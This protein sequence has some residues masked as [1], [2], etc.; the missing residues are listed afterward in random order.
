MLSPTPEEEITVIEFLGRCDLVEREYDQKAERR[1]W[2]MNPFLLELPWISRDTAFEFLNEN[3]RALAWMGVSMRRWEQRL[4]KF[5][6]SARLRD[7]FLLEDKMR[8]LRAYLQ[9]HPVEDAPVTGLLAPVFHRLW[10]DVGDPRA[11][12]YLWERRAA[13]FLCCWQPPPLVD[14]T[15][16]EWRSDLSTATIAAVRGV[17]KKR[18][19]A[20]AIPVPQG[21][22]RCVLGALMPNDQLLY[23]MVVQAYRE[24][25]VT[26]VRVVTDLY[27]AECHLFTQVEQ[28][29]T[30][31]AE[32][33][34]T[35][36]YRWFKT[37]RDD[38]HE[39]ME[40]YLDRLELK[41]AE[42]NYPLA[43][44]GLQS[45]QR[46]PLGALQYAVSTLRLELHCRILRL[47]D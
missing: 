4:Q 9:L 13:Q 5:D 46:N 45:D 2:L 26:Q 16:P 14:W 8:I 40:R 22:A 27:I 39:E 18:R 35:A 11:Q 28:N 1:Y 47:D 24:S 44:C 37:A 12:S 10:T 38:Q 15:E 17:M 3:P 20:C 7:L 36:L 29:L 43:L 30:N 32:L 31:E 42:H 23:A 21:S 6:D 41:I 33:N 19:A 34:V 25:Y